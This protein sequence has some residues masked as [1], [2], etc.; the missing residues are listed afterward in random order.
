MPPPA[1]VA[2]GT[3]R[4]LAHCQGTAGALPGQFNYKGL[5]RFNINSPGGGE[6]KPERSDDGCHG[7]SEATPVSID[8]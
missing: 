6:S 2:Q 4:A 3:A 5:W 1:T 8:D 7:A